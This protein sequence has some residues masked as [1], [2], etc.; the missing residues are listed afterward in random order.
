[1]SGEQLTFSSEYDAIEGFIERGWTDGLPIIPPTVDRVNV[2]LEQTRK[3]RNEVVGYEPV[4]ERTVTVEKVAI[5]SVMAGCKP[6]YFPI[7]LAAMEAVL[8]P[9]FNPHGMTASTMGSAVL[10]VVS[11]P[12]AREVGLNGST[13]VF[14][15]GHRANATIGRAIRLCLINATGSRSGEIDK[16]TLGHAGKYT[17]C[18]TENSESSPWTTLG[19]DRGT[20]RDE[21]SVTV[22]AGL[23]P[24]QISNHSSRDPETLL[25]S[26]KDALF[27]AGPSQTEIV[28]VLCPEHT[29]HLKNAGWSKRQIKDYLF[30]IAV[31]N[32]D[33]WGMGSNPPGPKPSG[34]IM[35]HSVKSPD[36][37][38]IIVAG[39]NAGAFSQVISLWG[40]GIGSQ[41]VN[42]LISQI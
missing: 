26:F 37:F 24:T 39:G 28:I 14:G 15:P 35:T 42:K 11:G 31:R 20:K 33:E 38:A 32:D 16:A 4:K 25:T 41:S 13:S 12:I 1:M 3:S 18:I 17:W 29:K 23:T 6:E 22:F 9:K 5:N 36:S 27:A 40:G 2:F 10:T 19:E 30:E 34:T 8:E 21:N 7:V